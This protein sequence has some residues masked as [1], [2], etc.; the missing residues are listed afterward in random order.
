M[1]K[2]APNKKPSA[3][4]TGPKQLTLGAAFAPVVTLA[5]YALLPLVWPISLLL[6]KVLGHSEEEHSRAQIKALIRT[7]RKEDRGLEIDEANMIH[8]VLE[9]HHKKAFHV[10]HQLRRAKMLPHDAIITPECVSDIMHWGHSRLFV[11][12]RDP[13]FPDKKDDII[14]VVLV[15]KLL[16]VSYESQSRLDSLI[17]AVKL[18]VV[19]NPNDNL[20]L[21]LNKFQSGTCHLAVISADP[22]ACLDAMTKKTPIPDIARPTMFCSLEDVIEEMLKEEIYDEEDKEMGRHVRIAENGSGR[23]SG[24]T[25][26]LRLVRRIQQPSRSDWSRQQQQLYI[27]RRSLSAPRLDLAL[28]CHLLAD[29]ESGLSPELE[30]PWQ[31]GALS[32]RVS[33]CRCSRKVN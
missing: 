8:G 11:Y 28:K 15:K 32:T 22:E 1:L 14:G 16:N 29:S 2:T 33:S 6:D 19:L 21:T 7:I 30:T 17:H 12:R 24:G 23:W 4:F 31:R 10:A 3:I 26:N 18:P 25:L 9:M 27:K 5:K 13:N 20:L